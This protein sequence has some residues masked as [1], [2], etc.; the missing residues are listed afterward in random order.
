MSTDAITSVIPAAS[1]RSR[2]QTGITYNT[3]GAAFN[4]G[5]TFAFNIIV[6]NLLGRQV[7]GEYAMIQSTLATLALIAQ[8]AAGCTATKYVAEFRSTDPQR[9][10]RI[11]G[12][13]TAFS[14]SVAGITL[15]A[16][17]AISGWLAGSVLKA[18]ALGSALAIGS[19]SLPFAVLN[20]LLL[21]ALAGLESYR[22]LARTLVWSG[23]A[24]LAICTVLAEWRGLNG[25]VAGLAFS[26]F[27]Q[28]ILLVLALRKECSLQGIKIHCAGITQERS[29]ILKFALPGALSGFTSM[30]ALWL[31]SAFLVRQPNGYSQMAIYSA[32]FSLMTL[33]LFLPNIANNVGMS[34][35]NH[36][37]GAGKRSEYRRAVRMNLAVSTAIV[38][39]GACTLAAFGPHLLRLFGKD[40]DDGYRVLL[41]LLLAAIVQ[42]IG[43]AMY[44]II[45]SQAKMWLSFLAVACPRDILVVV[46]VYVLIP[47]HGA[48]GL[49]GAYATAWTLALISILVITSRHGLRVACSL[50]QS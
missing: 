40:F 44:Q 20:G 4:Q 33:V 45:H 3:I 49:A 22:T 32:S 29:I 30:P 42:S 27:F 25:A 2:F 39:F 48:I 35:I 18:P 21:G 13:L 23:L 50:P 14:A 28:F 36:H 11:L 41:I 5:S 12:V 47:A 17:L 37:K 6:A 38:I 16:L 7:F 15:L 31:A 24:Y 10:G 1:L 19:A 43:V 26:A 8:L 9:A 46:L 34:L